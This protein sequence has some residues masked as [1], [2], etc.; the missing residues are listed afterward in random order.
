MK[1][2]NFRY[3]GRTCIG[4]VN[5]AGE[6]TQ[7]ALQ[8]G[9][10]GYMR[11]GITPQKTSER[12][13]LS[14]VTLLAPYVPGKIIGVGRNYADHAKELKNELPTTPLLFAK[15]PS[16]VIGTGEAI[17]WRSAHTTQV[18]YEGELAVIIGKR[19]SHV[20][21]E[22][23]LKHVFGYTIAN[24]V[25]ARDLQDSESQW[26]RAKGLDTFCPIGPVI[27]SASAIEDPHKLN[28]VTK[29]NDKEMQNGNTSD[30]IFNIP[31]LISYCSQS[32]VLEPGDMILTGTPSGVGKAQ[33]PP[34]FL[35]DG[36]VVTVSIEG[37]GEISNPC[38]V[39]EDGA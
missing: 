24:D 5:D 18:D 21:E 7:F 32:F 27:V 38:K 28:I 29:L 20:S 15:F 3:K 36:D 37:I 12:V 2:L 11:R 16:S 25:S 39:I 30:M 23:A 31:Y 1:L 35:K 26:V 10:I 13:N 22:D 17:I 34:R 14:D 6:I 19:A 33:K 8:D 9:L 4:E